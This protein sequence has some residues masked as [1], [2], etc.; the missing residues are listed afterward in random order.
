MF[1]T[2]DFKLS[3]LGRDLPINFGNNHIKQV[4]TTKY[5]GIHLDEILNGTN[6]LINFS[7]K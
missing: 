2:T 3:N 7:Q 4:Q 5:L 6:M 1:L